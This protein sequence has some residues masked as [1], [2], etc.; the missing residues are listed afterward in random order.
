MLAGVRGEYRFGLRDADGARGVTEIPRSPTPD[1]GGGLQIPPSQAQFTTTGLVRTTVD[2]ATGVF[3]ITGGGTLTL[4]G[5]LAV[6]TVGSPALG[7]TFTPIAGS[8]ISGTFT[9]LSF[10]GTDY[11]TAYSPTTVTLTVGNPF[12]LT[13]INVTAPVNVPLTGAMVATF[14]DDDQSAG[15]VYTAQIDWG[16]HTTSAGAVTTTSGGGTVTGS[17]T[18]TAPGRH[19]VTTSVT[20]PDG[21]HAATTSTATVTGTTTSLACSPTSIAAGQ[22]TLCT[23]TVT[24][25]GHPTGSV[26]LATDG[27]GSFG[28]PTCTLHPL[29]GNQAACSASYTP[30]AVGTGTHKLTATYSGDASNPPS[31][32]STAVGVQPT[33]S[34][35]S[36]ACTPS[37]VLTGT[38]STCAATVSGPVGAAAPTGQVAF[39]TGSSGSF[40]PTACALVAGAGAS[41]S[42]S[43][44]YTPAA[45]QTGSHKLYANYA[46]D[47]SHTV[48]HG[49]TTLTVQST[50]ST[51]AVSC[52]PSPVAAGSP[53][54]CTATVSSSPGTA[55]P[56][57][58]VGFASNSSG[59]F[60]ATSCTLVAAA[61][62][63]A[64]CSVSYTPAA[65]QTGSHKIYAN[66]AG[67]ATHAVSHA[68]TT[69]TVTA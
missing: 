21:T 34:R 64:S 4:G 52:T 9:T 1:D 49:S 35:T 60:G 23:T 63:S 59:S 67:D 29:G 44:S 55:S 53:T 15:A 46:G 19:V 54:A 36:V 48:S 32:G 38:S 51:T 45:V 69:V 61:G 40:S 33:A 57:G 13:G 5:T 37:T 22:A 66:Y 16:D 26:G 7:A 68:N 20:D 6:V 30:T 43:V 25:S 10:G 41:A 50:A 18:Y 58:Q 24:G 42:C 47:A 8:T 11:D 39:A 12:H 2:A 27:R 65:V 17:H 3:G 31:N 56:T 14:T 28:P 62:A